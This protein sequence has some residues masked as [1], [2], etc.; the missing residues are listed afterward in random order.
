MRTTGDNVILPVFLRYQSAVT[1]PRMSNSTEPKVQ[2][3]DLRLPLGMRDKINAYAADQGR[4]ANAQIVRFIDEGMREGG[5]R[6]EWKARI[7]SKLDEILALL[8]SK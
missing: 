3:I 5:E 2:K 7:E 8:A 4:S 1:I 6:D